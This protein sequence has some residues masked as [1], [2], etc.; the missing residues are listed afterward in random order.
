DHRRLYQKIYDRLSEGESV[1]LN[2]LLAE[3]A[4]S[5]QQD[6]ANLATEADVTL[7]QLVATSTTAADDG[8]KPLTWIME[9]AIKQITNYKNERDYLKKRSSLSKED[10]KKVDRIVREQFSQPDAARI[11]RKR[12]E[13]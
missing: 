4:A 10:I 1:T 3:L 13:K 8:E 2:N 7:E 9:L 5:G 11:A 6:L 12:P